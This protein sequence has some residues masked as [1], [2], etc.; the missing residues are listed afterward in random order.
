MISPFLTRSIGPPR[1]LVTFDPQRELL[2][3]L[4]REIIGKSIYHVVSRKNLQ[5]I[6]DHVC[7][8]YKLPTP[9]IKVVNQPSTRE[10]GWYISHSRDG[11]APFDF[12]IS[13]N[14]GFHGANVSTMIHELSHYITDTVYENNED[15]GKEFMGIYMHLMAKYRIIPSD[16]FR[17]MARRHSIEI[18]TC[19]T[20][21][22][23]RG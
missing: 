19:F 17:L 1:R 8:Y 20:P 22:D 6:A 12:T 14:R 9:K 15:H 3:K 10:F 4:E 2:Y 23:I 16:C 5:T 7:R 21:A 11:E 18:G 13:L